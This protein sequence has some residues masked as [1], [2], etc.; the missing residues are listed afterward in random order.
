M[1]H[2]PTLTAQLAALAAA[3]PADLS[4]EDRISLFAAVDQ[5]RDAMMSPLDA[6]FRF[7][8]G[9]YESTAVRLAIDMK[10]FDTAVPAGGSVTC[11]Q[12]A[13]KAG[14]DVQLVRKSES[15]LSSQ[16]QRRP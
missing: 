8:F 12:L 4:E 15:N 11:A 3:P 7:S 14:A 16:E 1:A 13:E 6:V 2:I 10:I 9:V 5:A